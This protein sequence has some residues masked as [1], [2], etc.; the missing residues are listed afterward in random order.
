MKLCILGRQPAL[1]LAEL[2]AQVGAAAI[3]RLS[4][5]TALVDD[6]AHTLEQARLGGTLKIGEVIAQLADAKPDQG[7]D[8]AREWLSGHVA[9]LPE[10]K[11]SLGISAYGTLSNIPVAMLQKRAFSL[12]KIAKAAG[13]SVRVVPNKTAEL[14]TAQVLHNRL[15]DARN[16]ELLMVSYKGTLVVARTISVQN[17]DEYSDR[18]YGRPKRSGFVGMLPPKLAQMMLHFAQT[19]PGDVVLDPFC[20]T[21]VVLQEAILLGC[22][23]YGTDIEQKMIDFSR[24]NLE[25][26]R[27]KYHLTDVAIKLDPGDAQ[28]LQWTPPL[29]RVVCETYLGQPLTSVP[30]SEKLQEIMHGCN[31]ITTG[32]LKNLQPQLT[33]GTR[34]CVAIPAW[35]V[36][37]RFHHLPVIDQLEELGYNRISFEHASD[38][39]LIYH[40]HDQI[41]ARELLVLTRK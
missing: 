11:I 7:F 41:V 22:K 37:N 8:A 24:T 27:E 15:T 4:P 9:D 6:T 21:G 19:Q 38:Q 18:D 32:F 40:R 13:R 31:Q 26:L 34:L 30:S 1:S 20:G 28:T 17:I 10:G 33:P 23:V 36:Q 2:E 5:T 16:I 12:K 14:N 3:T 39:D 29:D 25:W 35:F